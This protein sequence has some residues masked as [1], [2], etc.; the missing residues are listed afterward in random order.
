[1]HPVEHNPL[2]GPL[3]LRKAGGEISA[4]LSFTELG[5]GVGEGVSQG[6]GSDFDFMTILTTEGCFSTRGWA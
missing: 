3:N 6:K 4:G 2:S 1:M 5:E